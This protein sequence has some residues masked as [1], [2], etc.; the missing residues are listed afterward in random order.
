M[1]KRLLFSLLLS[2]IA[3]SSYAQEKTVTGTVIG[4][5]GIPLPG[6]NV[7][8]KGASNRGTQTDFDGVYSLSAKPEETLV[9]SFVGF[10]NQEKKV[11]TLSKVDIVL[12][13]STESLDEVIVVAYG[14]TTRGEVTGSVSTVAG[15]AIENRPL[16]NVIS[17]LEGT[18]SGVQIATSSGQ[19]GSAPSIRIRGFGSVNSSQEPLYVVDGV[20]YSGSF[21]SLNSNDIESFT[22]LKDAASTA[23]YGSQGANGVVVITTKKGKKGKDQISLEVSQGMATR[24]IPEY[25]R[26]NASQYYEL[27]WEAYRN[28]LAFRNSN[29]L[30]TADANI[31]A[32]QDIAGLLGYNPFN[33]SNDQIVLNDGSI[34]PNASLKYPDDLSWQDALERTGIIQNLNFSYQGGTEK[35]D[36]FASLS[37][38]DQSANVI[39][40]DFERITGRINLNSKLKDWFKTGFNITGATSTSNQAVDGTTS[41]SSFVNPFRFSRFIGP[42]YPVYLHDATTGDYILDDAGNRIYDTGDYTE[43]RPAGASPGRHAIQE[44]LLNIDKDDRFA[45]NARTYAEFYFLNDFT[46]TFNAGIDKNFYENESYDNKIVGDGAP[47]GRASRT[48]QTTTVITYNQLLNWNKSFGNHNITALL[49]HESLD[50][51]LKYLYGFRQNQVVDGN[52]ELINFATT[53]DLE[54][55]SREYGKEG[56]FSRLNYNYDNRYFV[57]GSYRRDGSS[58]FADD[59]RWGNFYSYSG[60]WRLDQE[61]FLKGQDWINFLKLRASYGQVGNDSNL[62]NASL[63]FYASQSLLGLGNNNAGEPGILISAPG[64]EFLE[65]ETQKQTDLGLDFGFIDNRISGSFAYYKK[66]TDGLIFDVPLSVSSGL[67]SYPANIGNMFNRGLELDLNLALVRNENFNWNLNINASTIHNEFTEL[68]QEE[69]INGTKKYVVGGSIF[70]YW[71]R[72]YYGVDPADGSALY[73]FDPELGTATDADVRTVNGDLVTTNQNK[74]L[75]NSTATA[76]PDLFGSFTSTWNYKGIELRALFTY[77]IGGD[78]Y[79]TNLAGLLHSGSYGSALSTRILDRWQQPGDI[80]DIPRLD[81]DQRTAFEAASDRYLVSSTFLGLR[82]VSLSYQLPSELIDR[83]GLTNA[84]IYLNGENLHFWTSVDGLDVGQNFNGTTQ[85]RFAPSRTISLGFN[86]SL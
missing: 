6:V 59:A 80:T 20:I 68:P 27:M 74:A 47:D 49:G 72:E 30:S 4:P 33:V 85:N 63:S 73:V 8:I 36:Y 67:D 75:Y 44:N 46:F 43:I 28:S 62:S 34:N 38:L 65:W 22:V 55:F 56:Y 83:I 24:S 84:K 41:S 17:A 7:I 32:S 79:D 54:S 64:N 23:I 69:I 37:Y 78:T 76:L 86:L 15:D 2:L 1:V 71:L 11:G 35:T 82:Q 31:K 10:I 60:A 77:S 40:S 61:N 16:T 21:A 25:D 19:P 52:T 48:T 14:T 50:Y 18:A 13:E 66:V 51:D 12:A 3:L 57:A 26:V 81:T 42:I 45:I 5:D 9:F 39:N 58:R 70:D 29:P 53:V